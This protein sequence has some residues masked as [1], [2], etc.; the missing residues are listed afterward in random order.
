MTKTPGEIA[1]MAEAGG[2]LALTFVYLDGLPLTGMS[3]LEVSESAASA[4]AA[5]IWSVLTFQRMSATR[6]SDLRPQ[7]SAS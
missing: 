3:T 1:I 7:S 6:L 5:L 4:S 2:L